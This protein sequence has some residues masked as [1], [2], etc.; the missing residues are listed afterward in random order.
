MIMSSKNDKS[1]LDGYMFGILQ[2][3]MA[4]SKRAEG[5]SDRAIQLFMGLFT[6]LFGTIVV[7]NSNVQD[8]AQK[9]LFIGFALFI[10]SGFG[11]LTFAWLTVSNMF[12]Q[13]FAMER[14]HLFQYFH[15]QDPKVF[16]RYGQNIYSLNPHRPY[17]FPEKSI[18]AISLAVSLS[19]LA[20]IIFSAVAASLAVYLIL[21]AFSIISSNRKIPPSRVLT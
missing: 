7:I 16:E 18:D 5:R 12:R 8:V 4:D 20:L 9:Y 21:L 10:M 6:A 13:E 17:I 19:L 1:V 15:D 11:V 14:F 3:N 2:A